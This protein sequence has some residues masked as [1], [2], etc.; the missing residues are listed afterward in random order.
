MNLISI[1]KWTAKSST[2]NEMGK[3]GLGILE[4]R[5]ECE[6]VAREKTA[7]KWITAAQ[8]YVLRQNL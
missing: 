4:E 6:A 5:R 2:K 8:H 1:I 7:W 3:E